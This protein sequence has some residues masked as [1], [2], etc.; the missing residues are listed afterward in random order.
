MRNKI[1]E[2]FPETFNRYIEVFGVAGWV[3]FAKE[4]HA[5]LEVFN[6]KNGDL[7]N[8]F[9]CVK[10]HA[11]ELQRLLAMEINSRETFEECFFLN[12]KNP[13]QTDLQRALDK[14]C[15]ALG[16]ELGELIERK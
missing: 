13:F 7:V 9:R 15:G 11:P 16:C 14:I 12:R 2:Q 6:D 10:Y 5:E 4:K 3:L 8:L 1:I